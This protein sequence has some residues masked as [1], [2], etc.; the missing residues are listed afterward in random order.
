M[1]NIDEIENMQ[2]CP[3]ILYNHRSL[4]IHQLVQWEQALTMRLQPQG[5][6]HH[7]KVSATS[8]PSSV[9]SE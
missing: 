9:E 6:R 7:G 1:L 4:A 2:L 5:L 8:T 3:V